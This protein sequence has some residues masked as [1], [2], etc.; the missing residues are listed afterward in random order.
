MIVKICG[1]ATQEQAEAAKR[2]GADMIGFVFAA[3][4]KRQISVPAAA[5]IAGAVKGVAKVGVFVNQPLR[6]VR[7]I[8][9]SC[10]LDYIQLHGG[11]SPE[12]C[13]ELNRPAIKVFRVGRDF[14]GAAERY[15]AEY[16]L[17]DSYVPGV[18]G[19]T[20][21]P[22]DWR[23][24]RDIIGLLKKPFLLAGGLKPENVAEAIDMLRPAGVD[25][26]GGVET[27][28]QKDGEK[29]RRFITAAK[30]AGRTAKQ[31]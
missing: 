5:A 31:C 20:G 10:R 24:M 12:Y 21:V 22:F 18:D 15:Q 19:G 16:L 6:A 30:A 3:G 27:D 7:E 1:L 17:L 4:S 8:A 2:A 29:I 23:Q 9:D 28:G 14:A 26:S 11:E 25:V 13:R